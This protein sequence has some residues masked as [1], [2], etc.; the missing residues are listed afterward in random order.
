MQ[1]PWVKGALAITGKLRKEIMDLK[2]QVNKLEE[3]DRLLRG[4]IAK[5][6][7]PSLLKKET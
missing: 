5:R 3:E 2:Q 1:H 7:T 6:I 4:I